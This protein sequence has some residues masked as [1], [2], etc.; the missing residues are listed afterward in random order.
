MN[1]NLPNIKQLYQSRGYNLTPQRK[2]ITTALFK[3]EKRHLSCAEI[4]KLLKGN[5][6]S[7]GLSTVYRAIAILEE[8]GILKKAYIGEDKT[9]KYEICTDYEKQNH[10]H[11]ICVKCGSVVEV[12]DKGMDIL[13]EEI[14]GNYKF[15]VTE[16]RANFFGICGDCV[17]KSRSNK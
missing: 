3:S 12:K 5:K 7:I 4:Y 9:V 15:E 11:L 8:I 6:I 13:T 1:N 16:Q 10:F 17:K 2:A 14:K